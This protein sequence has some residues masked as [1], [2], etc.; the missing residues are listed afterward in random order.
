MS[1]RNE[2]D[3][4]FLADTTDTPWVPDNIDEAF[5]WLAEALSAKTGVASL[6]DP[7]LGRGWAAVFCIAPGLHPDDT[8]MLV[9]RYSDLHGLAAGCDLAAVIGGPTDDDSG[10]PI[11]L[12]PIAREV[13]R[14]YQAGLWPDILYYPVDAQAVT[15]GLS[16]AP[17][18]G[19]SS[20]AREENW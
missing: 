9:E 15:L 18:S 16:S 3:D 19:A 7:E 17:T 11:A 8:P 4:D 12:V 20:A 14:R 2:D 13:N 6:S 10:W 5:V 1:P